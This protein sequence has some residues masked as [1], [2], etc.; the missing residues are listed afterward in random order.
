MSLPDMTETEDENTGLEESIGT[1][2]IDPES[3]TAS[4]YGHSAGMEVRMFM[5]TDSSNETN[6]PNAYDIQSYY[7]VSNRP[8]KFS[9]RRSI[10]LI[11]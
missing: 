7:H 11:A 9:I 1:L 8:L 5:L 6:P 2:A 4:F 3:G 10:V